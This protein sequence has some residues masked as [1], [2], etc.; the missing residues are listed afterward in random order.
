MFQHS[1]QTPF[2]PLAATW[3]PRGLLACEFL[4][5]GTAILRRPTCELGQRSDELDTSAKRLERAIENYF[6]CG[7]L[8]WDL[9]SLDWTGVSNFHRIVLRECFCIPAGSTLTYGALAMRAGSPRAARAVGAAMARNRWPILIPC[10]RVVGV[11]GA[12]TGYSGT[13]GIATKR[14]LLV[15]EQEQ[16]AF[17]LTSQ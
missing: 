8:E 6:Q 16:T 13:G 1:I 10:H 14:Q 11:T 4:R 12:L 2:G 9:D 5:S 3:T 7:Q 15:M 17:T